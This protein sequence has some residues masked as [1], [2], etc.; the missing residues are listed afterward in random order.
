MAPVTARE[1]RARSSGVSQVNPATN[2]ALGAASDDV[3][4]WSSAM[5]PS[6]FAAVHVACDITASGRQ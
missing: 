1:K 4:E 2:A 3:V 6:I 5:A